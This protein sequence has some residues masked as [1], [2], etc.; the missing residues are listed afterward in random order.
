M[1]GTPYA[2]HFGE[3]RIFALARVRQRDRL[4]SSSETL[5]QCVSRTIVRNIATHYKPKTQTLVFVLGLSAFDPVEAI[6]RVHILGGG[7]QS[8]SSVQARGSLDSSRT[9]VAHDFVKFVV[10]KAFRR[11]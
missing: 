2:L 9:G 3:I 11:Y 10:F 1:S 4:S 7:L 8:C 6:F 5:F